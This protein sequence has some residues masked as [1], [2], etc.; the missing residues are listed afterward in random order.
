MKILIVGGGVAGPALA[1]FLKGKADITLVDKAPAWGNVGYAITLWGNGQKILKELGVDHTVLKMGYE[2]PWNVIEDHKGKILKTATFDVYRQYGPTSVITRSAL[3]QA[4][5]K[6]LETFAKVKLATTILNI[7]QLDDGAEVT[8]SDNTKEKFDLVAGADGIHSVVRDLAFGKNFIKYYGW[9]IYAF[10]TPPS[11][12]PPRGSIE[13]PEG[14]KI[15]LIYPLE[16]KAVVM[17]A[18]L[19]TDVPLPGEDRKKFLH[20]LFSNFTLDVSKIIDEIEDP[21]HLFHDHLAKIEMKEWYRGRVVLLG[22]SKHAISPVTGMG[23]SMALE[24]A[25]VL[26]EEL[27]ATN[28]ITSALENYAQRREKR[29]SKFLKASS[30]IERWLMVKSPILSKIRDVIIRLIP[31]SYFTRIM[32][33]ILVEKI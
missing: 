4:L 24:D 7:Q 28:D 29:I 31:A 15:C 3:Q 26:A 33:G 30:I 14:G 1:K 6:D 9:D 20:R 27:R 19:S 11:I 17:L 5:V 21:T 10:W 13:F 16:D 12:T 22:D 2:V 25:F 18:T 8:F 32:Q 23:T